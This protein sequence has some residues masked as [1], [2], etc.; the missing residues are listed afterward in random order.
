MEVEIVTRAL[1]DAREAVIERQ[2]ELVPIAKRATD[3]YLEKN[4]K[5][6]I[7]TPEGNLVPNPYYKI[8]QESIK[9]AEAKIAEF[10]LS[11]QKAA[12]H[13]NVVLRSCPHPCIGGK[14]VFIDLAG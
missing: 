2:S 1:L 9:A 10:E 12:T 14:F 8:D 11:V 4:V 6:L 7:Q 3:I 13:V 5:G